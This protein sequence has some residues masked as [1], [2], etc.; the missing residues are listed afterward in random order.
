M[1]ADTEQGILEN[2]TGDGLS[3]QTL[4]TFNDVDGSSLSMRITCSVRSLS[5]LQDSLMNSK[6]PD[7]PHLFVL[8]RCSK[9]LQQN[10][11]Q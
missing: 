1:G 10:P 11:T 4:C 8:L 3:C 5:P 9:C 6:H 7:P 2:E